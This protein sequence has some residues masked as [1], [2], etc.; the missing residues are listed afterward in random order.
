MKIIVGLG[1]PDDKYKNTYHNMGYMA[2]DALSDEYGFIFMKTKYKSKYAEGFIDGQK[3][4]MLKPITYM[5]LSGEAVREIVNKLKPDLNDILIV[6]DD[7][8]LEKGTVRFRQNGS[9]GTH[10]GMRNIVLNLSTTEIP[11]LRLGIKPETKPN[12]LADYVLSK[13]NEGEW[14]DNAV[15]L[16]VQKMKEFIAGKC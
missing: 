14:K 9:A 8:D 7:I 15:N 10:N 4:I 3:V 2:V 11:R 6:Y 1:N 16:A 12:D 5:N 13:V